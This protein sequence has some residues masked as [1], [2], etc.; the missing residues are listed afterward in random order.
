MENV[1]KNGRRRR[2][3]KKERRVGEIAQILFQEI[4]QFSSKGK[5]VDGT[6]MCSTKAGGQPCSLFTFTAHTK[7]MSLYFLNVVAE[8]SR[9]I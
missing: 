9:M 2:K 8:H 1:G 5:E 3:E 6:K 7:W 4:C